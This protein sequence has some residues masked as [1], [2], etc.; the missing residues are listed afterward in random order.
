MSQ[1]QWPFCGFAKVLGD[2]Y[3]FACHLASCGTWSGTKINKP[4]EAQIRWSQARRKGRI[5][6]G[7]IPNCQIAFESSIC[8]NDRTQWVIKHPT[9]IWFSSL[10]LSSYGSFIRFWSMGIG[11]FWK[12]EW[13]NFELKFCPYIGL[14]STRNWSK[15]ELEQM[16]L[17]RDI[18]LWWKC[19]YFA[20]Q[21]KTDVFFKYEYLDKDTFVLA[22][23]LESF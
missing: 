11:F 15:F 23:T 17:Y 3:C 22:Q 9:M 8:R 16:Y 6:R 4:F 21:P 13:L 12:P 10:L 14:I 20:T 7:D 19:P 18:N 5:W 1:T 2:L